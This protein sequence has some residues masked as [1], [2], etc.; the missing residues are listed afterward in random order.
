MQ[1]ARVLPWPSQPCA[2]A[3]LPASPCSCRPRAL[4]QATSGAGSGAARSTHRRGRHNC[5]YLNAMPFAA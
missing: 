2:F 4:P 3:A 5:C 1:R